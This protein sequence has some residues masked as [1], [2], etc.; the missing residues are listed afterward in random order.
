MSD[1][2]SADLIQAELQTRYVGQ[3]LFF[4]ET[5]GST[6]TEARRLAEQGAPEGAVVVC[7]YQEAGR[8]RMGRNWAAPPGSSL[9]LSLIL[10]P[11][12]Q[13]VQVLRAT[14]ICGLAVLDAVEA[15]TGVSAG[16]KWPNDIVVG[17]AKLGGILTEGG[18]S[19]AKVEYLVV[20]IGINVNLDPGS[21]PDGL[22]MPA[23]S[24]S[25]I[26]DRHV[27]RQP[28]LQHLL[29]AIEKRNDALRA[30]DVP[31]DEWSKRL[32]T[33]GS[34][35]SVETADGRVEGRAE[36]VDID[37]GLWVRPDN[38]DLVKIVAGDVDIL[39]CLQANRRLA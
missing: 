39:P 27:P 23:T 10:R 25:Y 36:S 12:L 20:G 37:G 21:L 16:L 32:T 9:L 35:V 3:T 14:M 4:R 6:N 8:G 28:L 29:R 26:L 24:L 30:G 19:G 17:G 34:H 1:I 31:L 13:P 7:D 22:R 38:R 11:D 2:L 15:A 18:L 33:L 5:L